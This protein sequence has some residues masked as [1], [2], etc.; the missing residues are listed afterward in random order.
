MIS[1]DETI[2]VNAVYQANRENTG[3][4]HVV[5][6]T[7]LTR[8]WRV[9]PG[10]PAVT[11]DG[12]ALINTGLGRTTVTVLQKDYAGVI[13]DQRTIIEELAPGA[14]AQYLFFDEFL[15]RPGT[16][17]DIVSEHPIALIALRGSLNSAFIW[18]NRAL[19]L[20]E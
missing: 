12:I 3:P 7:E 13:L 9:F 5:E 20:P 15:P 14:K 18:E 6:L 17:F 10:N 11:W 16:Y 4:A 8:Q 2:R 19:S 1:G